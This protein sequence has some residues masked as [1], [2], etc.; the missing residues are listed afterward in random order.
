MDPHAPRRNITVAAVLLTAILL[1]TAGQRPAVAAEDPNLLR[2]VPATE[3]DREAINSLDFLL[4]LGITPA[5]T[6]AIL[7]IFEEACRLYAAR[8]RD[9]SE[10]QP[11]EVTAYTAFLAE[12][13][14]NQ[15]FTPQ[16][17]Q[18]TAQAHRRAIESRESYVESVNQ[19]AERVY[20]QFNPQ[21]QAI[22]GQYTPDRRAVIEAF[23][24][25][26]ERRKA[27]QDR[28]A[29]LRHELQRRR[30]RTIQQPGG[31][32]TLLVARRQLDI[33]NR[34]SH[35][36]PTNIAEHLLTPAAAEWLYAYARSLPPAD[37]RDAVRTWQ[38]GTREY[39]LAV[40]QQNERILHELRQQIN[41]WNLVN[42]MHFSRRQIEQ[43]VPLARQA[44]GLA[45]AQKSAKPKD[46]LPRQAYNAAVVRLELAAESVLRPGQLEVLDT[47]KPCLLPPKDLKNPVRVGQAND[48]SQ[49]A[50]WLDRA[51]QVPPARVA[52]MIDRMIDNELKHTG[53]LTDCQR[54]DREQLVAETVRKA[55]ALSD[56]DYALNREDL[57]E[58]I[59]P[60]DR[61]AELT[62]EIETMQRR[63]LLPGRTSRMLLNADFARVLMTRYE[64]LSTD[65]LA[66]HSRS[67]ATRVAPDPADET[68]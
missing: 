63:R 28:Q 68:P 39:P 18:A 41:N 3:H 53:P 59:Q 13:R 15:G 43:L 10:I 42:G 37:V 11:A 36:Q 30:F 61:K 23:S 20:L 64:Q 22:A 31:D 6:Q 48:A 27:A 1:G 62:S 57:A 60:P 19:L 4:A 24:T 7:P 50:R 56:V 14:L 55:A 51:R 66:S 26:Q 38:A 12:D 21:Q 17:E 40:K 46:K 54:R 45:A 67:P 34:T 33:I 8:Y 44:E 9:L 35:P 29:R 47:Y 32:A 2:S 49:Q 16:G 58:Q 52:R 25:W 5:Q 65:A